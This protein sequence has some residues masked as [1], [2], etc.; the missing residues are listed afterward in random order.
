[1]ERVFADVRGALGGGLEALSEKSRAQQ[2]IYDAWET[3]DVELRESLA[4][5]ALALWPDC[6][7]AYVLLAGEADGLETKRALYEKGVAAG[8]RELGPATFVEDASHFWGLLETRPYMRARAGLAGCLWALGRR[9]EAVAHYQDM[10]RLNP[11]DNQGLR[12]VLAGHLVE[13]GQDEALARLLSAY[14]EDAT[15]HWAYTRALLAFRQGGPGDRANALL[16]EARKTNPH[17]PDFLLGRKRMQRHLPE[18]V[19]FGDENEAIAY[20]VEGRSA[21]ER[22]AGARDWLAER[23]GAAR[24]PAARVTCVSGVDLRDMLIHGGERLSESRT[25]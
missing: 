6:A 17:V 9:E 2:L 11:N 20:A 1:M 18:L 3:S 8:E 24:E 16:D 22:S 13:L 12:F 7:D 15:A 14:D 25:K 5:E 10:L 19:G 4:H 23:C 21:W